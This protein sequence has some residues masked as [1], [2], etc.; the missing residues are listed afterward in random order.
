MTLNSSYIYEYTDEIYKNQFHD[1]SN[2]MDNFFWGIGIENETYI[3]FEKK[4]KYTIT[5]IADNIKSDRY[6]PNYLKIY[7]NEDVNDLL[8][9][10]VN[11]NGYR[12]NYN[13]IMHCNV[14][15]MLNSYCFDKLD[16][17]LNHVDDYNFINN[18]GNEYNENYSGKNILEEWYEYDP[19]I[20]KLFGGKN[21][22]G[23]N[24]F[25]DGESIEFITENFYKANIDNVVNE[26]IEKKDYF[27]CK[28]QEF[29][30]KKNIWPNL[31]K[32][33]YPI[34]NPGFNQFQTSRDKFV[35][36]NN[37]TYHIH[38]T[39]PTKIHNGK[40]I[41][42]IN[43]VN[44][45]NDING[46]AK[47]ANEFVICHHH[48]IKLIQWFEPFYI[49]T[50]G[51]P[52]IFSAVNEI[53]NSNYK[54]PKG[55]MRCT[56]SRLIGIGTYNPKKME[57]GKI[58]TKTV[59]SVRPK[60]INNWWYDMVKKNINYD[61]NTDQI[62]LDFNFNKHYQ[63][64]IEFR[65][66]DSFPIE[67]LN[68]V[69][70]SILLICEQSYHSYH[71]FHS[72]KKKI[73]IACENYVWNN[74]VYRS[75]VQ[76][77]NVMIYPDEKKEFINNI[78]FD[79]EINDELLTRTELLEDFCF[80]ILEKLHNKYLKNNLILKYFC[81]RAI[82]PPKW[83]NFNKIQYDEHLKFFVNCT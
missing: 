78:G 42:S 50:L 22:D 80:Y 60:K 49:A 18:E 11:C 45:I 29:I 33:M 30:N 16:I 32:I 71:S 70:Y 28:L 51:S 3:Q 1:L 23:H 77:H 37:S 53:T 64:G 8:K 5:Y 83:N 74:L 31:G 82:H 2:K 67:Y 46:I 44:N 20:S 4:K 54:Y 9:K 24:I 39:L 48:A 56:L 35:L 21:K 68:D 10:I 12:D 36:F 58:L 15:Q 76:G 27:L 13:I 62:G 63:S 75:L 69:I 34:I 57:M 59:D 81:P 47:N 19:E 61:I 65:L 41:N 55:S 40:I 14:T 7:K 73:N 66:F 52:D 17:K 26:L 79:L 6:S 43:P 25:F 72:T 38:I